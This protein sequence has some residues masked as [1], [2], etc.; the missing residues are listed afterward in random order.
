MAHAL[1]ANADLVILLA[2]ILLMALFLITGWEKLTDFAGTTEYMASTGAPA[3]ALSTAVAIV[4]EF[5]VGIALVLGVFTRPLA[6]LMA[7]FTLGTALIGHRYWRLQGPERHANLLNFYKNASITGGLL[8]LAITGPGR[9][10]L[11]H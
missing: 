7:L 3:P 4:M 6:L 8:L 9:Y 11:W 1:A 5:G 2:R 10:A